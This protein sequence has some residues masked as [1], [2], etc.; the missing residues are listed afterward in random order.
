MTIHERAQRG[1]GR[2]ILTAALPALAMIITM[3]ICG[4]SEAQ[5]KTEP[6]IQMITY[7]PSGQGGHTALL[8]GVVAP[9]NGC[10]MV[11]SERGD[12]YTLP[13]IPKNKVSYTSSGVLTIDEK[14]YSAGDTIELGGG[15]SEIDINR[16]DLDIDLS[17]PEACVDLIA[18]MGTFMFVVGNY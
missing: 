15:H 5:P 12:F 11:K 8:S 1:L 7:R 16:K 17:I 9:Q 2:A 14:H 13:L 10:M 3:G 6:S 18:D 4:C